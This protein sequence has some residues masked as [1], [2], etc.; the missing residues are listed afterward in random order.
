[1]ITTLDGHTLEVRSGASNV[2]PD[3]E[4]DVIVCGTGD[5]LLIDGRK[6]HSS[7]FINR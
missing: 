4:R 5:W 1:M 6:W 7:Y 3:H 2:P